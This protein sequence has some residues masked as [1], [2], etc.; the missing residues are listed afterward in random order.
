MRV[1]VT[2]A[3]GFVGGTY[4]DVSY[5]YGSWAGE[6]GESGR[7]LDITEKVADPAVA[8]DEQAQT[9]LVGNPARARRARLS[10][11]HPA[12]PSP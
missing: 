11:P 5:A 2:G 8:W 4:P 9:F 1:A 7:T 10:A 12:L 3:A 6:L